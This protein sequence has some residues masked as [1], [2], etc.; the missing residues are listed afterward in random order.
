MKII[1]TCINTKN[2]FRPVNCSSKSVN[3]VAFVHDPG[4]TNVTLDHK[5][6]H[7]GP[8]FEIDF[9]HHLKAE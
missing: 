5:T 6:R 1:P 9:I 4:K 2:I 3:A 8:F 7:K